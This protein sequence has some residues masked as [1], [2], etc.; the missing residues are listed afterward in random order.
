[1]KL[2]IIH[3]QKQEN[4][5]ANIH[6]ISNQTR[7][8]NRDISIL[9]IIETIFFVFLTWF[10]AYRY[11]TYTHIYSSILIAPLLL[12]KTNFS[13]NTAIRW[14]IHEID[15][16]NKSIL[17]WIAVIFLTLLT[18]WL[19]HFIVTHFFSTI[20]KFWKYFFIG[21][22]AGVIE[23]IGVILITFELLNIIIMRMKIT[24]EVNATINIVI[25]GMILGVLI[26]IV[27][28]TISIETILGSII[29][30]FMGIGVG[31]FIRAL[32]V[33]LNA[34]LYGIVKFPIQTLKA[35]P[36]NFFEQI[37]INDIAYSPELLP[38]IHS[39]GKWLQVSGLIKE[40]KSEGNISMK[41]IRP[42]LKPKLQILF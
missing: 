10:I 21:L 9:A 25:I 29:G 17:F 7:R 22:I 3:H 31:V 8:E 5:L 14:F 37:A 6:F 40:F 41:F 24:L 26:G 36:N 32:V 16:E 4:I 19:S 11:N 27:G 34:T 30:L 13:I 18:F 35:I 42:L 33:K 38:N 39:K 2:A 1:M 12:L 28:I 23:L 20:D 15:I